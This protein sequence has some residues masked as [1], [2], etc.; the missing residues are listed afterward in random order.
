MEDLLQEIFT[1]PL[2]TERDR[3]LAQAIVAISQAGIFLTFLAKGNLYKDVAEEYHIGRILL[4]LELYQDALERMFEQ[5]QKK[6][7]GAE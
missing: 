1:R 3:A 2:K 5:R 4:G 6:E 7:A